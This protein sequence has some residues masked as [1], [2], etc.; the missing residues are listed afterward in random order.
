MAFLSLLFYS[1]FDCIYNLINRGL[2]IPQK[3]LQI[4]NSTPSKKC[5]AFEFDT[6]D[7]LGNTWTSEWDL[8]CDKEYLKIVA[9]TFFLVG[10]ATGG[11][12]SGVLSD[13][14]GRKR[15]LFISAVFQSIFGEFLEGI[16]GISDDESM[17]IYFQDWLYFSSSPL[18]F[19]S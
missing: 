3:G 15:M 9:E 8:V 2:L 1:Y 17:V 5:E 14:F 13:K 12:V 18:R 11:I 7:E 19:T 10:V 6:N 16:L 4:S